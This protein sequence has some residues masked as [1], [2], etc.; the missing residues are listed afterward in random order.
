MKFKFRLWQDIYRLGVDIHFAKN[1]WG[2]ETS[3]PN[4][5]TRPRYRLDVYTK[6]TTTV[7]VPE[8]GRDPHGSS[9]SLSLK[10]PGGRWP[11]AP[12]PAT[13]HP[14]NLVGEPAADAERL[15]SGAVQEPP[16]LFLQSHW[17]QFV[18]IVLNKFCLNRPLI[19]CIDNSS[20]TNKFNLRVKKNSS[21]RQQ[22]FGELNHHKH[23][24]SC[25]SSLKS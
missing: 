10:M 3:E 19:P 13:Q 9:E 11:R 23:A 1:L 24:C 14:T 17:T 15:N 7:V 22:T 4:H 21:S 16:N 25:S 12:S 8:L 18:S 20:T 5:G 6:T 2:K